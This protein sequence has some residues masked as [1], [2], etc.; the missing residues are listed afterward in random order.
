VLETLSR[1][2][3]NS[4]TII[5]MLLALV[6]LGGATIKWFS[7]ALLIGAVAG[8]YSSTFIAVPLLLVWDEWLGKKK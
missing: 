2:I 1:S 8:T 4:V 5:L 3:N 7:L 6:V